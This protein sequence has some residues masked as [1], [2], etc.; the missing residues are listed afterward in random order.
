MCVCRDAED[1]RSAECQA[2]IRIQAWYRGVRLRAYIKYVKLND[3][4]SHMTI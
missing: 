3:K 2:V 4:P 1:N